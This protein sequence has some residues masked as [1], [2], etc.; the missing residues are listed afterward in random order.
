MKIFSVAFFKRFILAVYT[1]LIVAPTVVAIVF[2]VRCGKL[3]K[4]LESEGPGLSVGVESPTPSQPSAASASPGAS[5]V[6]LEAEPL[7]YQLLYPEL[8][9]TAQL[10]EQRVR[11]ERTV[12]LTFD[13]SPTENTGEI[14]DILDSYQVKA[15]FFVVGRTDDASLEL[16]REIVNR[17]HSIGL[18]SYSDSYQ[19]I[20]RSIEDYLDDFNKIYELVYNTTGV[21]A[22]IFRFPTGSVNAYNSGIYQELIAEMLRRNFVFFDWNVT[23]EDTRVSGLTSKSVR[24][25]VVEGVMRKNRSIVLLHDSAGKKPVVEALSGIIEDLQNEGYQ[26]QPLTAAVM[27]VIFS[28][29]S[30]P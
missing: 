26:F 15:T 30:V 1:L 27:P 14:L 16:L 13:C 17:G 12:Y 10:P 7:S 19:T 11:A 25:R 3:E 8:Y 21:R 18:R 28:Y 9:G 2:A 4:Q 20:Y 23:G 29:K 24:E 6:P 22:E 5:G